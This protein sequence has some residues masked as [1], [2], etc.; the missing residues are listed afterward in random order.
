M[1]AIGVGLAICLVG[2]L[3][4]RRTT[5]FECDTSKDCTGG[6]T[7]NQGYCVTDGC[8]A[9]CSACDTTQRTC[10]ITCAK[11]GDC[12]GVTCPSG[13]SCDITC[14]A[15]ADCGDIV[16]GFEACRVTCQGAGACG[17]IDCLDSCA[18][19]VSCPS[20]ACGAETCPAST[21]MSGTNC[22]SSPTDCNS[23]T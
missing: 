17:T 12:A 22:D 14:A 4:S 20:G 16:C 9:D 5:E 23:C 18:C 8:P 2:C 19:D 15:G 6:R 13:Y 10:T 7:C 3:V 21:C 1:K 11:A